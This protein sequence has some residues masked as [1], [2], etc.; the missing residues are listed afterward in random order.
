VMVVYTMVWL[1]TQRFGFKIQIS[2]RETEA[3]P[4]LLPKDPNPKKWDHPRPSLAQHHFC[5]MTVVVSTL[6]QH[7]HV[8]QVEKVAVVH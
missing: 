6:R 8:T 1:Y 7:H 4:Y 2:T 5:W 3:R